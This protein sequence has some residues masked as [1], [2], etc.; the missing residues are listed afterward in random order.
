ML[1]GPLFSRS[2]FGAETQLIS[3]R[4]GK[5]STCNQ[6]VMTGRTKA[7][8]VDFVVFSLEI[9]RIRC[10]PERSFW[11]ETGAVRHTSLLVRGLSTTRTVPWVRIP[12]SPP[13][14]Q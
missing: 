4:F 1:D 6:T 11:C 8:F 13:S 10:V 12:L 9:D 2:T 5:R 7:G 3:C 14:L